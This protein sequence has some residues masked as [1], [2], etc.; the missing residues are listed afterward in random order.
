MT[1]FSPLSDRVQERS[2]HHVPHNGVQ[3]PSLL[4]KGMKVL[5]PSSSEEIDT[6]LSDDDDDD[7]I[8]GLLGD[9][10]QRVRRAGPDASVLTS[11][12]LARLAKIRASNCSHESRSD[13]MIVL[14]KRLH[15][16]PT[17]N[18]DD[19]FSSK[20]NKKYDLGTLK[21]GDSMVLAKKRVPKCIHGDI[22][23]TQWP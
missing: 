2:T 23:N 12:D 10:T 22:G 9:S 5:G 11:G 16:L 14:K 13:S 7:D 8:I 3:P 19:I 1:P 21:K 18:V 20:K 15:G 17:R 6:S 4:V